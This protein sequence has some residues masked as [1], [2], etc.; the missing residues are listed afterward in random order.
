MPIIDA[1]HRCGHRSRLRHFRGS[2]GLGGIPDQ[3]LAVAS[4]TKGQR[5]KAP[6]DDAARES[7]LAAADLTPH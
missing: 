2:H 4:S 7:R 3:A 6:A 1:F 5:Q